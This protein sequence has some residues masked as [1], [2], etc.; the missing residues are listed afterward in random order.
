MSF[1]S[2]MW[3][4]QAITNTKNP[5]TIVSQIFLHDACGSRAFLHRVSSGKFAWQAKLLAFTSRSS[6]I[7]SAKNF[8]IGMETSA[9]WLQKI[10][11]RDFSSLQIGIDIENYWMMA[12]RFTAASWS[13]CCC[14]KQLQFVRYVSSAKNSRTVTLTS[15]YRWLPDVLSTAKWPGPERGVW[16]CRHLH[17][18]W[19]NLLIYNFHFLLD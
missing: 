6:Y 12:R 10:S 9:S 2:M 8:T 11:R 15:G 7:E 14:D 1:I 19:D 5:G 18:F 16:K 4:A 3:R 13:I 17:V